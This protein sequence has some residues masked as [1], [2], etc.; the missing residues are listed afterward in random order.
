MDL[1]LVGYVVS[2]V[3]MLRFTRT[4]LAGWK[5]GSDFIAHQLYRVVSEFV[6]FGLAILFINT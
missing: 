3:R 4:G 5:A 6:R 2:S 1:F